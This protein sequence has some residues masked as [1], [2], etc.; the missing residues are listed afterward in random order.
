MNVKTCLF[1]LWL[2]QQ[3]SFYNEV[4]VFNDLNDEHKQDL[5]DSEVRTNVMVLSKKILLNKK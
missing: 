2:Q 5:G 3:G 4:E 1:K